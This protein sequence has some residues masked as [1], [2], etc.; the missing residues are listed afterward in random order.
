MN[1]VKG[2]G[3]M[4]LSGIMFIGVTGIVRYLG[5]EM[6]PIQAAFIRYAFGIVLVVPVILRVGLYGLLST[7]IHLHA[8]RGLVH[9]IGVML[10]FYAMSRL[11]IAEVTA[12]GFTTPIFTT[13]GAMLILGERV[14]NYRVAGILVGFIGA[15]IVLR[16]GLR[17]IDFGAVAM[18]IAAPLFACSLLMAK[19]ATKTE[20]SS[21][22]VALLSIF[23]TLTL[24]PLALVYWRPPTTEEWSLLFL[25]AIFATLGHYCLTRAF[26]SAELS[27]L[28]PFSFLQLV[29]ATLLGLVVFSEQPDLWLWL[30]AGVIVFSATWIGRQEV[31]SSRGPPGDC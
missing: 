12:L 19:V 6:H 7:R 21:V 3:W 1:N 24:L 8:S 22:I 14:K 18:L 17:I 9:G 31:R 5:D 28:Q 20:S 29:W 30:G 2:I 10:W 27:A 23:C 4:L 16:P 25:T 13:A 26:Q 15:L 11:P